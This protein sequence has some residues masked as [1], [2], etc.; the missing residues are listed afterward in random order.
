VGCWV[1]I[2]IYLSPFL[3][4]IGLRRHFFLD[5]DESFLSPLSIPCANRPVLQ[6]EFFCA[7]GFFPLP[8]TNPEEHP[9]L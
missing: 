9:F 2:K 4:L 1:L 8:I 6:Q 7:L 5:S 3:F